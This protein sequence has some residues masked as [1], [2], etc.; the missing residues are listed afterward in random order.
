MNHIQINVKKN[1]GKF[2]VGDI[3]TVPTDEAGTPLDPFWRR[4]LK[5]AAIDGCCEIAKPAAK[6]EVTKVVSRKTE[7]N[8]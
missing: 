4:R 7:E 5:D 2:K 1:L 6:Q 3:I 8:E